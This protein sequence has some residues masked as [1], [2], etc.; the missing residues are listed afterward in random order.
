MTRKQTLA[1]KLFLR[2]RMG[3]ICYKQADISKSNIRDSRSDIIFS[4]RMCINNANLRT[5]YI[6]TFL[7][8]IYR[9]VY[10]KMKLNVLIQIRVYVADGRN[11]LI[12][13]ILEANII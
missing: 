3:Y 7:K 9:Y 13:G 4:L 5:L 10:M 12:F 2:S 1:L 6:Q 11:W 8:F